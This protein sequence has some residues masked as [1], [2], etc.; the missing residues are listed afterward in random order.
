MHVRWRQQRAH[1]NKVLSGV[2]ERVECVSVGR[3]WI[4]HCTLLKFN[5]EQLD[6]SRLISERLGV[7][8][9]AVSYA[10]I[11]DKRALTLQRCTIAIQSNDKHVLR[12]LGLPTPPA[13][14]PPDG[15]NGQ[16]ASLLSAVYGQLMT[17]S[18]QELLNYTASMTT[19]A[20]DEDWVFPGTNG[21]AIGNVSF[22]QD[23]ILRAGDLWGNAF[24][25][26]VRQLEGSGAH[27]SSTTLREVLTQRLSDAAVAGVP[28]FFG[29]QRM[30][31]VYR[32]P[33][34]DRS[35]REPI[36][37]VIG[38]FLVL[39]DYRAAVFAIV[40]GRRE[41]TGCDFA[42][43]VRAWRNYDRGETFPVDGVGSVEAEP[44]AA[45]EDILDDALAAEMLSTEEDLECADHGVIDDRDDSPLATARRKFLAGC[46]LRDV[47][48]SFP[49]KHIR[50]R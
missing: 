38:R 19:N 10:G 22:R 48:Q 25:L 45:T 13:G 23:G 32:T 47:I 11:K 46:P 6:A 34:T 33:G 24:T 9:N 17:V 27:T 50:E 36:G 20:S 14:P 21:I 1:K 39:G 49:A 30:G 40:M 2:E 41:K 15:G 5:R 29:S 18:N 7:D 26:R 43:V 8:V 37:P 28:N 3:K 35:D 44:I 42:M 31:E 16:D 12:A 4:V